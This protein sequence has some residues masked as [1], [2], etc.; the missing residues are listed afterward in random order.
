M[1]NN[2]SGSAPGQFIDVRGNPMLSEEA[3]L[4]S[5]MA[6]LPTAAA[7][8]FIPGLSGDSL[9]TPTSAVYNVSGQTI[10]GTPAQ[11]S[12]VV[13]GDNNAITSAASGAQVAVT[14]SNNGIHAIGANTTLAVTGEKDT[15]AGG[16][17]GDV[18]ILTG[19][20][21]VAGNGGASNR[22]LLS[23]LPGAT[24]G[25]TVLDFHSGSDRI[26]V[27]IAPGAAIPV[28]AYSLTPQA[29]ISPNQFGIGPA[30]TTSAERFVYNQGAGDLYFD[31][32]GSG[33]APQTLIGH[34]TPATAITSQDIFVT[35]IT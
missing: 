34:F 14:G 13:M 32:D 5:P 3:A 9:V 12:L 20:G 4:I 31:P 18:F 33:P 2:T 1:Q 10:N 28:A 24:S 30:A 35:N 21:S 16:G 11:T 26:D 8:F 17:G 19:S 25:V 6:V 15:L 22:F 23:T 7:G 29:L 27:N